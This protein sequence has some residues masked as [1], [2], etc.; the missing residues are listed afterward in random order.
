MS[1]NYLKHTSAANQRFQ[2]IRENISTYWLDK[3]VSELQKHQRE[4]VAVTGTVLAILRDMNLEKQIVIP[5]MNIVTN[6]GDVFYAQMGAAEAPTD[7]FDAAAAGWHL[8]TS[9]AAV[10]K[11]DT[12]VTI[13]DI[14]G[15]K[16]TDATYPQTNDGDADNTGALID[17]TTWRVSYT[18]A[19]AIITGIQEGAIVDV[20]TAATAALTHFLFAASFN[21]T[22]SDTLKCF[23]NHQMLG[24]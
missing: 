17:A 4:K 21:K 10:G 3:L 24:V 9:A 16:A 11:G 23:A 20:R 12:D 7:D 15:R 22:A 13:E 8:G 5:G 14:L 2:A 18:T 6:D 19:E 1:L